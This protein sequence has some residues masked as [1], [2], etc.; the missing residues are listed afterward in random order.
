MAILWRVKQQI[1][2]V[3]FKR[4]RAFRWIQIQR[5]IRQTHARFM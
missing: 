3:R 1:K 4:I 5:W 2:M